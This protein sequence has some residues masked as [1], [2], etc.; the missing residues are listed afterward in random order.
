MS[1]GLILG[2]DDVKK[3][4]AEYFHVEEKDV[5]KTQYTYIIKQPDK[6]DGFE[7]EQ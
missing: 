1:N 3:V 4:L 7:V 2:A 6:T 5:I